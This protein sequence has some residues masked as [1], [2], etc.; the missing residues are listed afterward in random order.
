MEIAERIEDSRGYARILNNMGNIYESQF[1]F[2]NAI[3]CHLKRAELAADLK[4]ADGQIKAYACLG[5]L[6]HL[7][8][9]LRKSI[10]YYEKVIINVRVKLGKMNMFYF[11]I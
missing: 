3:E 5:S 10:L 8:G 7:I 2:D 9:D 6:Y 4:D 1:D 11:G